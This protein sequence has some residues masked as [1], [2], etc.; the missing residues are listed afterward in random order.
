MKI[1]FFSS[2]ISPHM[3]PFCDYL[4]QQLGDEFA[5]IET[6]ELTEERKALGYAYLPEEIPYVR[7]L[8]KDK[9][10]QQEIADKSDCV[11]INTGS[12]DVRLV[13]NRIKCEKITFFCNERLFKRGTLKLADVRIWRQWLVNL[14]AKKNV[15][16]L[17]LGSFVPRDFEKIGFPKRKSYR[18]G[19]FPKID[20]DIT[21]V[22][23]AAQR[24][25]WVGRMIDWK[26]PQM[27]I[28]VIEILKSKYKQDY[29]LHMIGDGA[30]MGSVR[31][32]AEE[33]SCCE[34]IHLHGL[35]KND[36]VRKYMASSDALLVTSN[37]REGWGAVINE[38]L[39][40]STPVVVPR[41]VGAADYLIKNGYNGFSCA[42]CV[43]EMADALFKVTQAKSTELRENA[44]KTMSLWN[45]EV[46]GER[47]LRC[48]SLIEAGED[49]PVLYEDGPMS[50][51]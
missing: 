4:Y 17:A 47:F 43:E 28:R 37:K 9:R 2:F 34:R 36:E 20:G 1:A 8:S 46:A 41:C 42:D 45:A 26:R 40:A 25:L 19:Y 49:F 32:A 33:S 10:R 38:A 15:F 35:L 14:L 39:S 13:K 23:V 12:A 11:I 7:N 5:Y 30:L 31:K 27:A 29:E 48:L 22:S 21:P 51:A 44:R 3:K 6:Q 16:L 24:I 18:F 50:R